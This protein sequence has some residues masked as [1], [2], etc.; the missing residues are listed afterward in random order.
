M[1]WHNPSPI[2]LEIQLIRPLLDCSKAALYEYGSEFRVKFREDASNACLEIV[3][4]RIRHQL[5]PLLRKKFQ[6]A[7]DTTLLRTME[8]LAA[9]TEFVGM[10]ARKWL[11]QKE[12]ASFAEL[13]LAVQRR[14]VQLQLL[15]LDV[16]PNF[17]LIEHLRLFKAKP[18]S[19]S[20]QPQADDRAQAKPNWRDLVRETDGTVHFCSTSAPSF[21]P[22][23]IKLDLVKNRGNSVFGGLKVAWRI[24]PPARSK[25]RKTAPGQEYFDA[26]KVGSQIWLRHW[27]PGDRFQPIGMGHLVKLQDLFV[28]QKVPR[29]RRHN[30]VVAVS[31]DQ[32]LF[33][34]E[35]LR[36]SERFKLAKDTVRSLHWQWRK[37]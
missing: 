22:A 35:G 26:D 19:V 10:T 17:E 18:V 4:N 5:L 7:L 33:W 11:A 25:R 6:P 31:A 36:I 34:V 28:N 12:G 16:V 32:Q 24:L 37:S 13:P 15:A 1:K 9:E 21:K 27:R 14:C 23:S 30:L 20:I 29:E 8:V 2:R 3:R